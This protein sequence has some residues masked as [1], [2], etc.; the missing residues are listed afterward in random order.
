MLL[1]GFDATDSQLKVRLT[2]YFQD[3]KINGNT[4]RSV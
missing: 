2:R 4:R 3:Q 1:V